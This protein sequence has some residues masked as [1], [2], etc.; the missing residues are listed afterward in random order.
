MNSHEA[1]NS[2]TN[3]KFSKPRDFTV[4]IYH[5]KSFVLD[6]DDNYAVQ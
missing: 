2:V 6:I 5:I 4:L 1:K 3:F